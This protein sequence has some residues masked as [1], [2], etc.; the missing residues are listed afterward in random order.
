MGVADDLPELDVHFKLLN[1]FL[2][3]IWPIIWP[4]LAI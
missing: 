2:Q 4:I 1:S 3:H